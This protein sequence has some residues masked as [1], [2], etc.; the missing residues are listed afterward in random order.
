MESGVQKFKSSSLIKS[1]TRRRGGTSWRPC[2]E[3]SNQLFRLGKRDRLPKRQF[4][5]AEEEFRAERA[6]AK[7]PPRPAIM[8]PE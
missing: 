2:T 3:F 6:A 5:N 4:R 7:W 1:R 8:R